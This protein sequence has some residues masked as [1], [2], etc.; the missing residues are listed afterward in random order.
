MA[1]GVIG[2]TKTEERGVTDSVD[3]IEYRMK[4][5]KFLGVNTFTT[6]LLE[7][8]HNQGW[9]AGPNND[10]YINPPVKD[11]WERT[12]N[13]IGKY[14][15]DVLPYYEYAGAVGEK[16]IG[17]EKRAMTLAGT[18]TY[19]HITWSER[20]NA[21]IT[22]PD[23]ISDAK[24]LL[25]ATIVRYKDKVPF[26]GA[27]FRPRPSHMPISFSDAT[28]ARF[29]KDTGGAAV[30]REQLRSDKPLLGRYYSWWLGKRKEFLTALVTHLKQ[31]VDPGA[32][33]L[34][35][36]DSS[37]PGRS[38]P[39]PSQIVT[40]DPGTWKALL[41]ERKPG[42]KTFAVTPLS[43]VITDNRHL[44]ALTTPR[45]TWGE[46]EWQ[47]SDPQADPFAYQKGPGSTLLTYSMN[48]AYTV[49]NPKAFEAF[50]T[51]SGL[52]AV[53]HYALNEN[54]MDKSLGY[55]VSDVDRS[56]PYSVLTEVRAVAYGDPRYIGYLTSNSFS[57][58][59]PE[60]TRAFNA[61]FLSLPALPSTIVPNASSD[62]EVVVRVIPA[63]KQRTYFAVAHVGLQSKP[64]VM[65]T[66]PVAGTIK[67]AATGVTVSGNRTGRTLTLSM[68]PCQL[69][70]FVVSGSTEPR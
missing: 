51:P 5:M 50:R 33:V 30:T 64:K 3:W 49:S 52:A 62:P 23:T 12:L 8:G 63:G 47:H 6:D 15:L 56:G 54:Q 55:F 36:P 31:N 11:K 39:G 32:V 70:A 17:R 65:V 18:K 44:T 2:G 43:K 66:L 26:V 46:W 57:K 53:Y 61:A 25:D 27:W 9:D 28:L 13:R 37:E 22:D 20:F 69:R 38:L 59:F 4:Q 16:G 48:R 60:Y 19:T 42:G 68:E 40:D 24:R 7:F 58:G 35:T 34:L 10:W 29:S 21:D 41:S 67:D 1:D 45:S 14:G